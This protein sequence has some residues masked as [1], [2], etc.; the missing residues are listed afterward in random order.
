MT[1][2]RD[3]LKERGSSHN[4]GSYTELAS[5]SQCLK[6]LMRGSRGWHDLPP[7]MRESLEMISVK[8]ARI[9]CGD[10]AH[11]DHWRDVCGYA[12]LIDDRLNKENNP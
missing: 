8:I 10:P 5:L 12:K 4:H 11:V 3:T 2:I 7:D 9:L 1:D 6:R